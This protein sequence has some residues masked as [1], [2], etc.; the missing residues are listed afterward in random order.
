MLE[1]L[2]E[3]IKENAGEAIINNPAIPNKH[4]NAAIETASNSLFKALQGAAKTGGLNSIKDLFREGGDVNSNPI[5]NQLSTNVAG[6][7]MK[8]FGLDKGTAGSI[9]A[10]LLPIV[11]SKLVKKTNDPNDNSFNLDGIIGALAGNKDSL[12]GL[13]GSLKGLLGK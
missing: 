3:L 13:L 10:M 7:L 12:G 5:M 6:D 9:V 4:N 2:L 8:K 1:N 11:M